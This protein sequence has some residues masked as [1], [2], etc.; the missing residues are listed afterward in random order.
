VLDEELLSP[1]P[2]KKKE[3][4][5]SKAA[6]KKNPKPEKSKTNQPFKMQ[7]QAQKDFNHLASELKKISS[8]SAEEIKQKEE[9]DRVELSKMIAQTV[10][11]TM[12]ATLSR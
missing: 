1:S 3:A 7:K 4:K 10:S 2:K 5:K 8:A 11:S 9:K 6:A 12:K